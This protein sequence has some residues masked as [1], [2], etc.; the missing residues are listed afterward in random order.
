[1]FPLLVWRFV[2]VLVIVSVVDQCLCQ[3]LP[4]FDLTCG[5][6]TTE[7]CGCQVHIHFGDTQEE[8][9]DTVGPELCCPNHF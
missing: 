8:G 6:L 5:F 3:Q 4:E 2:V 9:E 1:M 7:V